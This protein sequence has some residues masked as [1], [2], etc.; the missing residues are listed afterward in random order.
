MSRGEQ[1]LQLARRGVHLIVGLVLDLEA[2][3]R[4]ARRETESL[5][6]QVQELSGRLALN[7]RNSGKPPSS[8]G[9]AKPAPKPKS[10]RTRTGRRPGGQPGHPGRTLEP[11]PQPDKVCRHTLGVCPCGACNGASLVSQPVLGYVK[12]QVFELPQKPLE[13]A[14]HQAEIKRC[15]VSGRQ[16]TAPFPQGVTAPAQYGPRFKAQMVYLNTQHFI[17]F[18]RLTRLC[19]DFYG[20]PLSE[21]TIVAANQLVFENLA[22]FEIKVVELLPQAPVNNVDESGLRVAK[23]LHWLHVASN[24]SMTFYG[25]HP[26]RGAEAMDYFNILPHCSNWLVH[27]HWKPYFSYAC[28]HAL[29]NEHHLRELKFIHEE[30]HEDWAREMSQFLL[31]CRDRKKKKGVL[32]QRQHRKVQVRYRAILKRG[33]RLHP[34]SADPGPK[35]KA[36]NLLTRLQDFEPCVLAFTVFEEVPF[37]NNGG[38]RDIR[39]EKTRQGIS[40]CFRTLHGA[41]VFA[42]IRSYI[43]T[44]RKQGRNILDALEKAV[45]GHP[46]MPSAPPAGP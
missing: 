5:R 26:K 16:V 7:S 23:T 9:L 42:R 18:Q 31:G 34:R 36:A 38:E 12:R 46:F 20:Q 27:D 24:D 35:G 40:G 33:R 32:N 4:Q 45:V 41:R 11:A 21:G 13:V 37:T 29:C 19:E 2:K 17:P 25:V 6:H 43:S 15:P 22:P 8:D 28:L 3:L 1:L 14:E 30:L 39:M 44:C 10:L